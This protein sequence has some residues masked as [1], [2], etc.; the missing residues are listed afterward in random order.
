MSFHGSY[1]KDDVEILLKLIPITFIDNA[2]QKEALIQSGVKHYSE[3]LSREYLPSTD[4]MRIFFAAHAANRMRMARDCLRLA[5]VIV[6]NHGNN[7]TLVSL[8]RAGTPVG[9]VL[10]RLI[11]ILYDSS[12]MHFSVSIIRDRGIDTVALDWIVAAGF[13]PES[14]A[15]IDGWTGKGVISRE[16][17]QAVR[18]YNRRRAVDIQ[19]GL[20]VLSDLAGSAAYGASDQDYLISPSILNSTISGLISRSVLNEIIGPDDFHGCAFYPEFSSQDLSC[21]FVDDVVRAACDILKEEGFPDPVVFRNPELANRRKEFL[22]AEMARRRIVSVNLLK[23]GIGEATRALLRRTP[24]LLVI[25]DATL[26]CVSHLLAL[27][28]IKNIPVEVLPSLPY[29]ALA[30]IGASRVD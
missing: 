14:I 26:D 9:A 22:R 8:V 7:P 28:A 17:N 25:R 18:S 23:P 3:M 15:F 21:W 24:N 2:V 12:P 30:I 29:N 4:Y 20:Y 13:R 19:A 16:L 5:S 11:A 27:A 1:R 10:R 6:R